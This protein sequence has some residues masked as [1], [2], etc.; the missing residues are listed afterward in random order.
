MDWIFLVC[1]GAWPNKGNLPE[2]VGAW[3]LIEEAQHIFK[4]LRMNQ[5]VYTFV[6][7][8]PDWA[9]FTARMRTEI[10]LSIPNKQYGMLVSIL[11]PVVGQT[12]TMLSDP[13]LI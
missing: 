10:L 12:F 3:K 2:H 4:E 7:E 8:G 1:C 6:F 9:V 13:L 5:N 11:S